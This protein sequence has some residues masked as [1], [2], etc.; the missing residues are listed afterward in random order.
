VNKVV[1][2]GSESSGKTEVARALGDHFGAPVS[3]EFVREF[4]RRKTA[5][6]PIDFT[7]HGPIARGQMA[8]EDA[9]IARARDLVILDTD[10]VSTV[11]YCTHY[12]GRTPQWI[13]DEARRRSG[14][15]YLLMSPDIPW[16][17]DG[18]RDRGD[19]RA[20]MHDLFCRQLESFGLRFVEIG[21][22]FDGR[23]ARATREVAALVKG[24]HIRCIP[25]GGTRAGSAAYGWE[26][27]DFGRA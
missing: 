21:G 3:V 22:D 25:R 4:A 20:E 7:D 15:L 14:D 17:A 18:V 13:E 12:F 11:V 24:L 19:R 1:L 9:A 27:V 6:A 5:G 8:A 2:T 16:V 10:L 23:I 26:I